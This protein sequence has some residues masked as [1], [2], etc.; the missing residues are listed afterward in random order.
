MKMCEALAAEGHHV[1]LIGVQGERDLN[2]YSYYGTKNNFAVDLMTL[3]SLPLIGRLY[4]LYG[5]LKGTK[6]EADLY[7]TRSIKIAGYI[8]RAR[9]NFRLE[10]HSPYTNTQEKRILMRCLNSPVCE[11]IIVITQALKTY[12]QKELE[13]TDSVA[14]KIIVVPD[15]ASPTETKPPE[16]DPDTVTQIGYVGQLHSGKGAEIVIQLA[17]RLPQKTFHI[18]GGLDTQVEA[19]AAHAPKNVRFYGQLPY[20]D[21][22]KVRLICDV[23]LAPYQEKVATYGNSHDNIAQW[24]SPLKLFEYMAAR[25]AIICSDLPVL[26][27]VMQDEVNC[28][29]VAHDT[30][31]AWVAAIERLENSTLRRK[32]ANAA[33]HDF[34][35]DYTWTARAKKI[36][37]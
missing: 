36:L 22:E 10:L 4:P 15:A 31:D 2:P 8:E 5:Y 9:R 3:P 24:M 35:H 1:T 28:L 33:Y 7:Y 27:E 11:R 34:L 23:L 12:L 17:H 20:R 13:I 37:E 16:S 19:L 14:K 6:I 21:A 18:V 30:I 25:K 26:R 29:L 32:L